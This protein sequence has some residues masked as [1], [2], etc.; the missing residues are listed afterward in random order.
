MNYSTCAACGFER[1]Q[2][3]SGSN[4]TMSIHCTECGTLAM[5]KSP[6]AVAALRQR[7]TGSAPAADTRDDKK[8]RRGGT[9]AWADN[10]L[11]G[12]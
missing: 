12:L 5:V 1:A 3:K 7:M 6:K 9:I 8:E 10:L 4:G 2:I 11:K